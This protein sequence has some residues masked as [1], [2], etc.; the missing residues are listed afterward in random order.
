VE[1]VTLIDGPDLKTIVLAHNA[2]LVKCLDGASGLIEDISARGVFQNDG[3]RVVKRG[4]VTYQGERVVY[5][6]LAIRAAS[7]DL[8][9]VR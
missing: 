4:M 2:G 1:P 5:D 8:K 6:C 9:P 7:G 3:W